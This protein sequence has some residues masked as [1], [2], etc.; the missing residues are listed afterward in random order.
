[1]GAGDRFYKMEFEQRHALWGDVGSMIRI[2][3]LIVGGNKLSVMLLLPGLRDDFVENLQ[4]TEWGNMILEPTVQ[5]W[6]DFITYSDDPLILTDLNAKIFQRKMR[7]AIS[8]EI[9]Q[10]IWAADNFMCMYCLSAKM[11]QTLMTVDHFIPLEL[12]GVNDTSNYLTACRKCNKRKGSLDPE[13]WMAGCHAW[14]GTPPERVDQVQK[15][16][17][18]RKV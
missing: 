3:G 13:K 1:M 8:G 2:N 6:S 9:Q 7:Y 16:L 14:L 12:G 10:K 11:G 15:Y 17:R 5:E 18:E 4:N